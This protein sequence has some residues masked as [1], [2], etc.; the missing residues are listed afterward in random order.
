M[1]KHPLNG[2][3]IDRTER[4]KKEIGKKQKIKNGKKKKKIN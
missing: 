2:K 3:K 1:L 4:R